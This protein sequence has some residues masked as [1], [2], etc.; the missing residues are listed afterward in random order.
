[1]TMT[2]AIAGAEALAHQLPIVVAISDQAPELLIVASTLRVQRQ[3]GV[4]K[5]HYIPQSKGNW[6]YE[7]CQQRNKIISLSADV[8]RRAFN[9]SGPPSCPGADE[10]ATKG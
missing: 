2:R 9:V 5:V 10:G 1:M 4:D 6:V 3:L 8:I 7:G